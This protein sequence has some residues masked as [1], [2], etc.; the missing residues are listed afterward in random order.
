MTGKAALRLDFT[1][2]A[3]LAGSIRRTLA[4]H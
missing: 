2:G 3:E 4:I 1:L